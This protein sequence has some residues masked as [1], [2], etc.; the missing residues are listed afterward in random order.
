M[1]TRILL[2]SAAILGAM[3]ACDDADR[4]RPDVSSPTPMATPMMSPVESRMVPDATTPG[5]T[6]TGSSMGTSAVP[7]TGPGMATET[8][9]G[10]VPTPSPTP[11]TL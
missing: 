6:G 3:T 7:G 8:Q 11:G 1:K 2:A 5:T 9:L 4:N 10:G